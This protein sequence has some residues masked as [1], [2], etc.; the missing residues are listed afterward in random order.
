MSDDLAALQDQTF[1]RATAATADSF[2]PQRRLT[3]AQLAGYLDQ[4]AFAVVGT[5]R[6]DGR[7]HTAMSSYARRGT[8]FW[9]P[10]VTGSVRE[11]NVRQQPWVTLVVAEGDHDHHVVVLVEGTAAMLAPDDVPADVRAQL[12]G[13]WIGA[14]LRIEASR[15]LSYA[16]QGAL[17]DGRSRPG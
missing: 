3:G 17:A 15:I 1:A 9:L 14:W 12:S 13:D 2:P 4:R 7:P 8:T 11:R 5:A 6:P 10:T 16:A